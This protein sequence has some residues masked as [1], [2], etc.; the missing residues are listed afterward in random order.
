MAVLINIE[1][2]KSRFIYG[3]QN[4]ELQ[5]FTPAKIIYTTMESTRE[6][7]FTHADIRHAILK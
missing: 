1:L 2:K 6:A 4:Q 7:D 5:L 3:R